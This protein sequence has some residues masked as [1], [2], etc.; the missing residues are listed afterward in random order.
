MFIFVLLFNSKQKKIFIIFSFLRRDSIWRLLFFYI[1]LSRVCVFLRA[2]FEIILCVQYL[3]ST[4]QK[5]NKKL[6]FL[7][8]EK[9]LSMEMNKK[10]VFGMVWRLMKLTNLMKLTH[11]SL[12]LLLLSFLDWMWKG[13][14][15][16]CFIVAMGYTKTIRTSPMLLARH[17]YMN[18]THQIFPYIKLRYLLPSRSFFFLYGYG[19]VHVTSV[20]SILRRKFYDWRIKKK[21]QCK[22]KI[23][24]ILTW[25]S[26]T[27]T[28]KST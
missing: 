13:I 19:P 14:G 16:N 17:S 6:Q 28:P 20:M 8:N 25:F 18:V 15:S 7:L 12:L 4:K 5:T 23:F 3:Q 10:L 9:R 1:I 21:N 2:L 11:P 22:Q 24:N 27:P 26:S